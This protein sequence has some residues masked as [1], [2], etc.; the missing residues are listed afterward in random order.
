MTISSWLNFGRLAPLGR[1]LQRGK[2][3]WLRL[4]IANAQCL[5]L[6]WVLFHFASR[7]FSLHLMAILQVSLGYPVFIEAKDDGSGGDSWSYRSSKAPVK[8]LPL[9]D[10]HQVFFYRPD[11]LPVT[12]PTVSKH[13]REVQMIKY[14]FSW[15]TDNGVHGSQSLSKEYQVQARCAHAQ[16]CG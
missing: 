7:W 3:F 12:Q 10:Q 14:R 2:K 11:A 16:L 5:R 6:L 13:W 9:T 15:V 4:T 8:S 1:G